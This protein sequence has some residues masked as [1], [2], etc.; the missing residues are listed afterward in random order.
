MRN[1]IYE[2][3][4]LLGMA[5]VAHAAEPE[6]SDF[7]HNPDQP[8]LQILPIDANEQ[9]HTSPSPPSLPYRLILKIEP[10]FTSDTAPVGAGF[11][12]SMCCRPPAAIEKQKDI[13]WAINSNGTKFFGKDRAALLALLRFEAKSKGE[14]FEIKPRRHSLS[15]EWRK[16][17]Q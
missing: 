8:T 6:N 1:W 17:F 13:A 16:A 10:T 5:I 15:I 11:S 3:V 2:L 14:Y 12:I 9:A 7:L 4:L